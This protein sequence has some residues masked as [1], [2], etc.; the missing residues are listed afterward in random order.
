[1]HK[2][3]LIAVIACAVMALFGGI[4]H[5]GTEVKDVIKMENPNYKKHKK[6][7]VEF[8]HKKHSAE[9]KADCGECHHD[10]EGEPLELKEGDE[11]QNCIECHKKPAKSPKGKGKPKLTKEEK[12]EYHADAIHMN[13]KGCHKKH[14]KKI[15]K[16]KD[17]KAKKAP[18]SCKKCHPK[19][20]K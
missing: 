18:T 5:A 13:C 14:N 7:I 12:L 20:K 9:Y 10:E 15:K 8:S 17:T 19:N 16:N 6:G 1:M 3:V 11:V 2:K 4:I